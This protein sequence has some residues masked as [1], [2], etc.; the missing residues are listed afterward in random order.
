MIGKEAAARKLARISNCGCPVKPEEAKRWGQEDEEKCQNHGSVA[1]SKW[2]SDDLLKRAGSKDKT[3]HVVKGANHMF[4]SMWMRLWRNWG[5]FSKQ[6]WE[7]GGK[8]MNRR[9]R[10]E[11]RIRRGSITDES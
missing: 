2:M 9:K 6:I 3:M 8:K 5:R 7:W 11:G 4:R 10:R 1:A